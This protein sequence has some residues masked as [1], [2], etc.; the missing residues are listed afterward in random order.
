MAVS[1]LELYWTNLKIEKRHTYNLLK[2][3]SRSHVWYF[4]KLL[5][6]NARVE[7]LMIGKLE[8]CSTDSCVNFCNRFSAESCIVVDCPLF[9]KEYWETWKFSLGVFR[10]YTRGAENSE[11][12][13]A[14]WEIWRFCFSWPLT[15]RSQRMNIF[16]VVQ[17]SLSCLHMWHF[18]P[19]SCILRHTLPPRQHRWMK[20][21]F[22]M[23]EAG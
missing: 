12:K 16:I 13:F 8:N 7:L 17:I 1:K 23:L 22:I 5:S 19:F 14:Q 2:L 15:R 10:P 9:F 11:Q 6:I 4:T 20:E 21:N 18:Y 3:T